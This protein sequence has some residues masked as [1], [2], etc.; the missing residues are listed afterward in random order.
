MNIDQIPVGTLEEFNVVV[1][2]PQ[3]SQHKYEIDE[4]TGLLRLYTVTR[5]TLAYPYNYGI[6]PSTL[7]E[8]GDHLDVFLIANEPIPPLTLV[9]ARPLGVLE[10]IDNGE[11]DH[12]VL[13]ICSVDEHFVRIASVKELDHDPE[14]EL[15]S[16]FT[17][18]T[19]LSNDKE[20]SIIAF[21]GPEGAKKEIQVCAERYRRVGGRKE[22]ERFQR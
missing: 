3:G 14:A 19:T 11:P 20:Y 4:H 7:A 17:Q 15:R 10:L 22:E 5:G 8:D 16:F 2:I 13:A 6:I 21:H 9:P 18:I 1:E 12:K